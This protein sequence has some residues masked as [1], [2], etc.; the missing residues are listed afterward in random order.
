[1]RTQFDFSGALT[2]PRRAEGQADSMQRVHSGT[3]DRFGVW[4]LGGSAAFF[5]L[6]L[7]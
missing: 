5:V 6:K 7:K 4:D 3:V 1:M 2:Q